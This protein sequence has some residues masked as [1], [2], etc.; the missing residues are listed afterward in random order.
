MR[1]A[2]LAAVDRAL[3]VAERR[4]ALTERCHPV[5]FLAEQR[6]VLEAWRAGSRTEPRWR[7]A[8]RPE[9]GDVESALEAVAHLFP[10]TRGAA[11][12]PSPAAVW[13]QLYVARASELLLEA[14]LVRAIG[15]P[16]FAASAGVRFAL[17]DPRV[18]SRTQDR[19]AQWAR[20]PLPEAEPTIVSDDDRDP[21]SLVNVLRRVVGQRRLPVRVE[22]RSDLAS[23]AAASHEVVVVQA[24]L[25]L[26]ERDVERI[27]AHELEAHVMPRLAARR[28]AVG[29]M[30]VGTARAEDEEGRALAIEQRTRGF[31]AVRRMELGR[32]HLAALAVRGG[33][34]W[35]ETV[36]VVLET[37]A[38]LEQAAAIA[39]RCHRGGGLAREVIYLT[40]LARYQ[41]ALA[42]GVP[43]DRWMTRGRI[44]IAAAVQLHTCGVV[45]EP[46]PSPEAA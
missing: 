41:D 37:G 15:T 5:N 45:P 1:D 17:G 24:G 14:S 9:L 10:G 7:Y 42:A 6:R 20:E 40:A 28:A 35:V 23:A 25:E 39:S 26:R 18:A 8:P 43:L 36:D 4:V 33:A 27:V 29:L 46:L 3:A 11:G 44:G 38:D 34:T 2:P 22:V 19:A 13:A 21:R 12:P 30:G 31:D 32:R 16:A